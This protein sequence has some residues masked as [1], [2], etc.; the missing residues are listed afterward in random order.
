MNKKGTKNNCAKRI[1]AGILSGVLALTL[2]PNI[3]F[4]SKK[5]SVGNAISSDSSLDLNNI[6]MIKKLFEDSINKNKNL[7]DKEKVI[8]IDSFEENVLNKYA[9]FMDEESIINMCTSAQTIDIK[10]MSTLAKKIGWWSGSY[11]SYTNRYSVY[12]LEDNFTVSHENLH[13][14]TKNGL[15]TTGLSTLMFGYGFNEGAVSLFND[16][17]GYFEKCVI[18]NDLALILGIEKVFDLYTNGNTFELIKELSKYTSIQKAIELVSILDAM[19]FSEYKDTFVSKITDNYDRQ[20]DEDSKYGELKEFY[21]ESYLDNFY[22]AREIIDEIF[23]NKYKVNIT[24][25]DLGK[26]IINSDGYTLGIN[27]L[28]FYYTLWIDGNKIKI[29]AYPDFDK[30]NIKGNSFDYFDISCTYLYSLEEL[31]NIKFNEWCEKVYVDFD[32]QAKENKELNKT[33]FLN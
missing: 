6:E 32:N 24:E 5:I 29:N 7:S 14:I 8:I 12:S 33:K 28:D 11:N 30:L 23:E 17:Y 2:I 25:S 18:V 21:S 22:K 3:K 27:N 1:L 9:E 20:I 31:K 13:A 19:V 10:L 26:F 16:D 15:A 4:Y